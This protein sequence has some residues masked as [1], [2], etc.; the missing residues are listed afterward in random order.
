[1]LDSSMK[2]VMMYWAVLSSR[3]R[4]AGWYYQEGYDVLDSSIKK[5]MMYWAVL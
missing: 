1:M 5:V 2:K 3:L 4:C